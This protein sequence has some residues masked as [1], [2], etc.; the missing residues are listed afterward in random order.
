MW[1]NLS[2]NVNPTYY[3]WWKV[4]STKWTYSVLSQNYFFDA[5]DFSDYQFWDSSNYYDCLYWWYCSYSDKLEWV[6]EF[7][8]DENW[9][10]NLKYKFPSDEKLWEKLYTLQPK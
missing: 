8:I 10:Y 4:I 9:T 1:E 7:N 2:L 3:F 6:S 5:K